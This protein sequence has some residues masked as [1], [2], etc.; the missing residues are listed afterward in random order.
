MR[1][2]IA[3]EINENNKK[4]LTNIAIDLHLQMI[5]G[6]LVSSDNYHLTLAFI[7]ESDQ[8]DLLKKCIDKS[9]SSAFPLIASR[10]DRF[11]RRDGDLLFLAIKPVP[12]LFDLQQNLSDAL[13]QAGFALEKR[14]FFPHLTLLRQAVVPEIFDFRHYSVQMP[15]V[16]QQAERISLMKSER[17]NGKLVYT[18]IYSRE[19]L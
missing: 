16:R 7:G 6:K 5:R 9:V 3:L 2:F 13:R 12:Q 18:A 11:R 10:L 4:V 17:I 19:L 14:Q 15:Q 8:V 1:L